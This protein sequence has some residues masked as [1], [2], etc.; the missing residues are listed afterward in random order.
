MSFESMSRQD[1][2][3]L[4]NEVFALR[5]RV[6][7]LEVENRNLKMQLMQLSP[8]APPVPAIPAS[9]FAFGILDAAGRREVVVPGAFAK[10]GTDASC[11]VK[12][13]GAR[14]MHAAIE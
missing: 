3:G 14:L 8:E 9:G 12:L 11:H 13:G 7:E 10:L 2:E 4:A 5:R 1:L 6:V